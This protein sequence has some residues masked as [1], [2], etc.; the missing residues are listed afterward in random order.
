MQLSDIARKIFSGEGVDLS[1]D[2]GGANA[3]GRRKVMAGAS[4]VDAL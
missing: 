3:D 4:V 2:L 1:E